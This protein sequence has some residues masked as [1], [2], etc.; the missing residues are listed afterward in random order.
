[1][2]PD[3]PGRILGRYRVIGPPPA[4]LRRTGVEV[5]GDERTLIGDLDVPN[6][7]RAD[8]VGDDGP[9]VLGRRRIRGHWLLRFD[10]DS[11]FDALGLHE[12]GGEQHPFT[13]W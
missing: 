1:M 9:P 13:G 3:Q 4:H 12:R 7:L 11:G 5:L 2:P 6:T 10:G 8:P